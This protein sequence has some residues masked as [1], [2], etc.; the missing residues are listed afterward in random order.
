MAEEKGK[1]TPQAEDFPQWYQDVVREGDLAEVAKVVKGM[2]IAGAME[3]H[4]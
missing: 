3:E 2:Y 1:I 4:H